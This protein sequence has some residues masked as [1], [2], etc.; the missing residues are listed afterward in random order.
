LT[1]ALV[2]VMLLRTSEFYQNN[3]TLIVSG[4]Y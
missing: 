1:V 3:D 4:V 2:T